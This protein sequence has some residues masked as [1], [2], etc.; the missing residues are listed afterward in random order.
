M[1]AFCY[2]DPLFTRALKTLA[3]KIMEASQLGLPVIVRLGSTSGISQ[4]ATHECQTVVATL[5]PYIQL[6]SL[7]TLRIAVT[8]N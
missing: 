1:E 7:A 8:E 3:P 2:P 6:F 4:D 5:S